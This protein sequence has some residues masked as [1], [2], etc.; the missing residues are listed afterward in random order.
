[1]S[2][3]IYFMRERRHYSTMGEVG[4]NMLKMWALIE[5]PQNYKISSQKKNMV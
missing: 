5:T 2:S 4:K 3:E 1:M